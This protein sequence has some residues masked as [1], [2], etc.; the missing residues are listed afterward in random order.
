[1]SAV[2]FVTRV[3]RLL[4]GAALDGNPRAY[5][6]YAAALGLDPTHLPHLRLLV[7]AL[8]DIMR[9]DHRCHRPYASVAAVSLASGVPGWGFADLAWELGRFSPSDDY[10]TFVTAEWDR[11]RAFCGTPQPLQVA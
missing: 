7:R 5:S 3:R 1:M 4:V 8:K 11:F 9:D 10:R 6:D 2:S